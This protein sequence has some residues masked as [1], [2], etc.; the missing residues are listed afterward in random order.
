MFSSLIDGAFERAQKNG[1]LDNLPGAGKP[2]EPSSLNSDPFAHAFSESGAMTPFGEMQRLIDA[3]RQK[4]SKET[5]H[6]AR[7]AIEIEISALQTRKAIEM[8]TWKRYG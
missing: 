1:E 2:I 5:D 8:E 6:A 7:R 3:A 4:L